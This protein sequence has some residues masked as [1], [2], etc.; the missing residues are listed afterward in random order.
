M[1]FKRKRFSRRPMS[2]MFKKRRVPYRKSRYSRFKRG[3]IAVSVHKFIR[4]ATSPSTKTCTLANDNAFAEEFT[5]DKTQNYTEFTQLYDQFQITGVQVQF[6]LVTNP[7]SSTWQG[8]T[9]QAQAANWY[10]KLWYCRDYDNSTTETVAQLKQRPE[11][12]CKVLRPNQILK[13]FVKPKPSI[14]FYNGVTATGYGIAKDFWLDVSSSSTPYFGLKYDIDLL[15]FAATA[16][17]PFLVQVEYKYYL[18]FKN[19]R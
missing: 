9:N 3:R 16:S 4:W 10:P 15:G 7:D 6:Q 17:Y 19:P 1:A 12:R 18:K 11:T 8:S 2:S 5:L 13:V 14:Q